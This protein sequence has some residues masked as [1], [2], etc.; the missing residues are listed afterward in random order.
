M[1]RLNEIGRRRFASGEAI[2]HRSV[3]NL[4]P[5]I[6]IIAVQYAVVRACAFV[7]SIGKRHT[8]WWC[9]RVLGEMR[10]VGEQ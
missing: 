7:L 1:A 3:Q 5:N 4:F 2:Y 9:Y 10:L 6:L 8:A